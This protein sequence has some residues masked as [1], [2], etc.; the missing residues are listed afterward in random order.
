MPPLKPLLGWRCLRRTGR[1]YLVDNKI[2]SLEDMR[3]VRPCYDPQKDVVIPSW[4]WSWHLPTRK[5]LDQAGNDAEKALAMEDA[6]LAG[7][8][9]THLFA[10]AGDFGGNWGRIER[11]YSQGIRFSLYTRFAHTHEKEFPEMK[12]VHG[13]IKGEDGYNELLRSSVFCGAMPGDGYSA[14]LEDSII[15]GCIPV[16]VQARRHSTTALRSPCLSTRDARA[17]QWRRGGRARLV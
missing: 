3:G 11:W 5:W 4:K 13:H 1:F 6:D 14:R 12:L 17:A 7:R 16:I 15:N 10:F 8:N 2:R 9:R